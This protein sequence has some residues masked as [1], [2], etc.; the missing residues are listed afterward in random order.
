MP[1]TK[2]KNS[3]QGWVYEIA[4]WKAKNLTKKLSDLL[5]DEQKPQE[6][7][8][9]EDPNTTESIQLPSQLDFEQVMPDVNET[10]SNS[11]E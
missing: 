1:T 7:N 4:D 8:N 10:D 2:Q 3:H 6:I 11:T 9:S 5:E